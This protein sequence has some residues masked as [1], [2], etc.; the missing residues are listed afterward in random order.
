[1]VRNR[2]HQEGLDAA[3]GKGEEQGHEIPLSNM[4]VEILRSLPRFEAATL[5]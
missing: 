2:S 1:M 3:G 4:A 5:C